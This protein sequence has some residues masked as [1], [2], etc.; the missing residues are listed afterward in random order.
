MQG[1][2]LTIYTG[3]LFHYLKIRGDINRVLKQASLG[4][5]SFPISLLPVTFNLENKATWN[6]GKGMLLAQRHTHQFLSKNCEP[7]YLDCTVNLPLGNLK[8]CSSTRSQFIIFLHGLWLW[9]LGQ[10]SFLA[11]LFGHIL[12]STM[13]MPSLNVMHALQITSRQWEFTSLEL[14][15]HEQYAILQSVV[16]FHKDWL[17]VISKHESTEMKILEKWNF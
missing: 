8:P 17:L 9:F 7:S 13:N 15:G 16:S 12:T 4:L 10:S 3:Y 2:S 6:K 11:V 14:H 5:L 1:I